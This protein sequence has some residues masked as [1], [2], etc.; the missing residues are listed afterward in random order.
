LG[1]P[2]EVATLSTEP[3]ATPRRP[4]GGPAA[5]CAACGAPVVSDQRY[6]LECGERQLPVS[7]F[8]K[9]EPRAAAAAAP[10]TQP[11][12]GTAAVAPRGNALTLL[13][14]IGVLLLAMGVGVLIGRSSA[15]SAR[16]PAP[17][18]ITVGTDG[19]AAN[20]ASTAPSEEAFKSDWPAGAKGWTVELQTLP[21]GSTASQLASAK[22]AAAGKG[23]SAVGALSGEEFPSVGAAGFVIYSGRYASR[24]QAQHAAAAL[25]KSFPGAKPVEVSDA[26]GPAS[27]SVSSPPSSGAGGNKPSTKS[28]LSA[29]AKLPTH[30]KTGHRSGSQAEKESAELPEVVETT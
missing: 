20:G 29:P 22:S 6:C 25:K 14:G 12:A 5:A 26:G 8:L 4:A 24:A 21:D 23:A 18:V 7:E 13:A 3:I 10:P 11:P 28:S 19:A 16:T 9:G 15:G 17:E 2:E 30:A 1:V 27:G